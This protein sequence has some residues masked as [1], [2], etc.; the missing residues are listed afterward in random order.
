LAHRFSLLA[1]LVVFGV[2]LVR[3]APANATSADAAVLRGA[4]A[5]GILLGAGITAAALRFR[6]PVGR[7]HL[8]VLSPV[9]VMVA[10]AI[11]VEQTAA[12]GRAADA[13][14]ASTVTESAMPS[15]RLRPPRPLVAMPR[16]GSAA[17]MWIR[18]CSPDA[19]SR[20]TDRSKQLPETRC[21]AMSPPLFT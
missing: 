13:V 4:A 19:S 10:A 3:V 15:D 9:L 20:A 8:A 7:V 2:V 18:P 21:S 1:G 12:E 16:T 5:A 6:R 17:V 14:R 11:L